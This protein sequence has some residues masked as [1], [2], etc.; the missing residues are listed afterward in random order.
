MSKLYASINTSLVDPELEA[1]VDLEVNTEPTQVDVPKD[2]YAAISVTAPISVDAKAASTEG[3]TFA[4]VA[5]NRLYTQVIPEKPAILA[6]ERI[7]VYVPKVAPNIAGI[8]KFKSEHFIVSNG[9]VLLRQSYLTQLILSNLIALDIILVVPVLPATGVENRIYFVPASSTVCNGYVW[10]ITTSTWLSLGT[11]ELNLSNYYT[12][13]QVD[14]LL[15][16]IDLTTYYNKTQVNSL[17][18][19]LNENFA[20]YYTKLQVDQFMENIS[21]ELQ[22]YYDKATIDNMLASVSVDLSNYYTKSEIENLLASVTVDLSNYYTKTQV[23]TLINNIAENRALYVFSNYASANNAGL[24]DGQYALI[25]TETI[26][27]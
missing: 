2:L 6:Q 14:T 8:A 19:S 24:L 7:F 26:E 10:D 23:Q 13:S 11:I 15:D 16:E 5:P 1:K 9:E 22:N 25:V 18:S 4:P 27:V 3:Q 20:N 12:K 17:L 21:Y